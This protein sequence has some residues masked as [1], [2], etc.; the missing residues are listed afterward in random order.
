MTRLEAR[1]AVLEAPLQGA[2]VVVR[3][4]SL[5]GQVGQP[6]RIRRVSAEQSWARTPNETAAQFR[7]R[8]DGQ[9][10]SSA[11]LVVLLEQNLPETGDLI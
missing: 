5:I 8:V 7:A 11:R 2:P 9:L 6:E 4:I 10:G 1:L 3:C